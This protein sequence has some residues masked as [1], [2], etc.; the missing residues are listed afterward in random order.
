[1][2]YKIG[3]AL[4]IK[5]VALK[6]TLLLEDL[7]LKTYN[8]SGVL[9]DTIVLTEIAGGLYECEFTPLIVGQ[10]RI[11]ISSIV[12][13]DNKG[14]TYEIEAVNLADVNANIDANEVKIDAIDGS[15]AEVKVVVD[16]VNGK[17]DAIDTVVDSISGKVDTV[18]TVV[19][20]VKAK[21]DNLPANTATELTGINNKL[22]AL[23]LQISEG[24]EIL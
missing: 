9:V 5:Y 15:V 2:I 24:G 22:D 18:D 19:D 3:E 12:N 17:V 20:A 23:D 8:P 21:T 16:A 1:M 6:K 14:K 10:Y 7:T 13:G 4:K 11:N